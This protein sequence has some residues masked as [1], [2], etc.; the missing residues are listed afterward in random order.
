MVGL[1]LGLT[2]VTAGSAASFGLRMAGYPVAC[3]AIVRWVPIVRNRWTGWFLAHQAAMA[4]I[5]FGWAVAGGVGAV[6]VNGLWFAVAATWYVSR[7]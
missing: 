1:V 7:S 6:T 2:T 4:A 5:V 3:A